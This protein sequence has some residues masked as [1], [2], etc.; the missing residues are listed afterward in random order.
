MEMMTKVQKKRMIRR[1]QELKMTMLIEE[2]LILAGNYTKHLDRVLEEAAAE[3]HPHDK[4]LQCCKDCTQQ[5]SPRFDPLKS[6]TI[7]AVS[8]GAE[9]LNI[10][11]NAFEWTMQGG[12]GGANGADLVLDAGSLF[13]QRWSHVFC[14][15][16]E[17]MIIP[18]DDRNIDRSEI[19]VLLTLPCIATNAKPHK[20]VTKLIHRYSTTPPLV[21]TKNDDA[22]SN[23]IADNRLFLV[24]FSIG[25]LPVQKLAAMDTGSGLV[26]VQC[27]GCKDCFTQRSSRFDPFNS[28]MYLSLP[29]S[30]DSCDHRYISRCNPDIPGSCTY[31]MSYGDYTTNGE[32]NSEKWDGIFG[33]GNFLN[34]SIVKKLGNRFSYCIDKVNDP[35][36]NFNRLTIGDGVIFE[37]YS[38]PLEAGLHYYVT[39]EDI[40]SDEARLGIDPNAFEKKSDSDA[41]VY[42]L[43]RKRVSYLLDGKFRQ[44]V[45]T[46]DPWMLCY[47]GIASRD[48]QGFPVLT[49]HLAN[50]ADLVSDSESLFFPVEPNVFCLSMQP[51]GNGEPSVIGVMAQP[52]YNV[53]FDLQEKKIYLQ[54]IDCQL[55]DD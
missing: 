48:V 25:E 31:F 35:S 17:P 12:G 26:W 37:G 4:F 53:A 54:R 36:Y 47:E 43:V 42:N 46:E 15:A 8:L 38:T 23:L 45:Y 21:Y 9:R 49:F 13:H 30:H 44:H 32:S 19:R 29:C 41:L 11:S 22:Q 34:G 50:G 27:E 6:S 24:K 52:Y 7:E 10:S 2:K 28:S 14:L 18:K 5:R 33:L 1:K 51:S 16:I 3:F 39:L 20:L 40:S 55:L